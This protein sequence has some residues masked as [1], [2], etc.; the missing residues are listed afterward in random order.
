MKGIVKATSSYTHQWGL[1]HTKSLVYH[2][3]P[4][5]FFGIRIKKWHGPKSFLIHDQI[6]RPDASEILR[7]TCIYCIFGRI[8]FHN[9]VWEK[10]GKSGNW[11]FYV[12]HNPKLAR[13]MSQQQGVS[14]NRSAN[15]PNWMSSGRPVGHQGGG[16]YPAVQSKALSSFVCCHVKH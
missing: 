14:Y 11:Q 16:F 9:Q 3:H 7:Y 6:Q 8:L 1:K 15:P 10:A 2:F 12:F 13:I 5:L 4:E